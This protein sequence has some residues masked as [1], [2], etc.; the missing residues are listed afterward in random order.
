[1]TLPAILSL[2]IGLAAICA[3]VVMNG[4][5][6]I[7]AAIAAAHW[8]ILAVVLMHLPQIFASA[9]AWRHLIAGPRKPSW[10]RFLGMRLIREAVN[11]LLPVAQIGGH[12]VAARL[13]A[14]SGLPLS[15]AG[16]SV[17]VDLTLEMLS[18]A[19][20]TMLGVGLLVIR[21]GQVELPYLAMAAII[22][23]FALLVGLLIFAQR[24]GLFRHLEN[25]LLR[26]ARR[27]QGSGLSDVA[28]LHLA[29][30]ALYKSPRRLLLGGLYHFLSWLLGGLEMLVAMRVLGLGG[31]LREGVI[32][33]S[34]GQAFRAFGF[35]VPGALGIQ[36]GGL[37]LICGLLGIN[38]QGAIELSLLRRIRE[39]AIGLPGLAAW[40]WIEGP[41]RALITRDKGKKP[42]REKTS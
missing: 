22:A 8:G 6:G 23:V 40:Y 32:I 34:L 15:Q 38:A 37:I 4:A 31:G 27:W 13:L 3:L 20:F 12:V 25:W 11:G 10:E 42:M 1:M 5:A 39:L 33:E 7:G 41:R 17:S 19:A 14:M 18:Q 29:I 16:A 2:L 30:I 21:P 28:G 26:L 35:L 9:Q 24:F 36:E